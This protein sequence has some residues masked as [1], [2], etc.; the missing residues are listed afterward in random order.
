MFH[1]Y[2]SVVKS[3]GLP[4]I[5]KGKHLIHFE[6]FFLSFFRFCLC[7]GNQMKVDRFTGL[8]FVASSTKI[9]CINV[10]ASER[11]PCPCCGR[12]KAAVLF[13]PGCSV[14]RSSAWAFFLFCLLKPWDNWKIIRE[15]Y[16]FLIRFRLHTGHQHFSQPPLLPVTSCL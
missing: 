8:C 7:L 10:I 9:D 6:Y 15:Q 12:N 2:L 13:V 11:Q 3:T 1:G 14:S 4:R 16:I 5:V